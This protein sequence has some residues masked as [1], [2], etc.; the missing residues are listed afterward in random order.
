MIDKLKVVPFIGSIVSASVNFYSFILLVSFF[1]IGD[2]GFY[3]IKS[4][5]DYKVLIFASFLAIST[6]G[7]LYN[8]FIP[9][10][11]HMQ[12]SRYYGFRLLI[13][14]GFIIQIWLIVKLIL[15]IK[16]S[17]MLSFGTG[18]VVLIVGA[19]F[20][21]IYIIFSFKKLTSNDI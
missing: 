15:I 10:D 18:F 13:S 3:R 17:A 1:M 7:L 9:F 14:I 11:N 4:W 8:A 12:K 19:V 21:L 5:D 2:R 16:N 20:S 6:M